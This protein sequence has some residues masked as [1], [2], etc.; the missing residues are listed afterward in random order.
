MLLSLTA[1]TFCMLGDVVVQVAPDQPLPLFYMDD[2]L[3][4][5]F[6]AD[7]EGAYQVDVTITVEGHAPELLTLGTLTLRADQPYWTIIPGLTLRRGPHRVDTVVSGPGGVWES[8]NTVHRIDRNLENAHSRIDMAFTTADLPHRRAAMEIPHRGLRWQGAAEGLDE[9]LATRSGT[10]T[11]LYVDARATVPSSDLTVAAE[12][13]GKP[14]TAWTIPYTDAESFASTRRALWQGQPLA[15][16]GA[17]LADPNDLG[18]LIRAGAADALEGITIPYDTARRDGALVFQAMAERSGREGLPISLRLVEPTDSEGLVQTLFTYLS[19]PV[20]GMTIPMDMLQ[21]GDD[22]LSGAFSYVSQVSHLSSRLRFVGT[23]AIAPDVTG[24]V[25]REKDPERPRAWSILLWSE[26][27]PSLYEIP[28]GETTALQLLDVLNNPLRPV[29]PSDGKVSI[30][31]DAAPVW[32]T[33][34]RGDVIALAACHLIGTEAKALADTEAY[35]SILPKTVQDA[36]LTLRNCEPS[37]SN[38][39]AFFTLLRAFPAL[40]SSMQA[41]TI[42]YSVGVPVSAA[43]A[44]MTRALAVLEQETGTPFL[45]PLIKIRASVAE[46]QSAYRTRTA[47]T[48]DEHA[49]PGWIMAEAS[50]LL[51]LSHELETENRGIE[52]AA[53]VSLAEWRARSLEAYIR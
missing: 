18:D 23:L 34:A 3:V 52:A 9:F 35:L 37:G 24:Y 6:V 43:I 38:R 36:I 31:L 41:A 16:I 19:L 32:L 51:A 29:V 15:R 14:V 53:L 50:R 39:L 49:R 7:T 44:R 46:F 12:S 17:N 10:D 1:L 42:P 8:T 5:E 22:S 45:E 40:E 48:G 25:F 47:T 13:A 33:G 21:P 4:M 28:V 26:G 27:A 2:P 30:T 20:R 11:N